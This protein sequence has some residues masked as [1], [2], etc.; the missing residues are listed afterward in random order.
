MLFLT[1]GCKEGKAGVNENLP[2]YS[3][4]DAPSRTTPSTLFADE[5]YW[6]VHVSVTWLPCRPKR[7]NVTSA[8][9]SMLHFPRSSTEAPGG[10]R[11]PPAASSCKSSCWRCFRASSLTTSDQRSPDHEG[12][13]GWIGTCSTASS[14]CRSSFQTPESWKAPLK[15]P[16]AWKAARSG[17]ARWNGLGTRCQPLARHARA[18]QRLSARRRPMALVRAAGD[19]RDRLLFA[20]TWS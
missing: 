12:F 2:A 6:P 11:Q 3:G 7:A 15:S 8:F 10:L 13:V 19:G 9:P 17:V 20:A 18:Q 1:T 16:S 4:S 14:L 5:S